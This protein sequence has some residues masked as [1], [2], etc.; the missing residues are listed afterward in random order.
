ML[1]VGI[2]SALNFLGSLT[3]HPL[4]LQVNG[5][6]FLTIKMRAS[7]VLVVSLIKFFIGSNSAPC[8]PLESLQSQTLPISRRLLPSLS[9]SFQDY[10]SK[11]TPGHSS[12]K[13]SR[14][15]VQC[16]NVVELKNFFKLKSNSFFRRA[17]L[18][19]FRL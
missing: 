13:K 15:A 8:S 3:K 18:I 10:R 9:P 7:C 19:Y 6:I 11:I 5:I 12:G 17:K 4:R 14:L 2:V 16:I 1:L